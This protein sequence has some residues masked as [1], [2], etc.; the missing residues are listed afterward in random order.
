MK[1]ETK[2]IIL[3]IIL[4][5]VSI[6]FT[7]LV[8]KFD[9]RTVGPNESSVGFSTINS[10]VSQYI[11]SNMTWYKITSILGILPVLIVII[12]GILGIV[13]LV[14]RKSIVK[15]DFEII[16]LGI[17]Y[18]II[19]ILYIFFEK[20]IV[21]YRPILING[22]LEASYP[23]SHTMMAIFICFS[24]NIVNKS[25]IKDDKLR[26]V[27]NILSVIIAF[28]IV[29]GRIISGVHWCSDIVGGVII[30][31]TLL[32]IFNKLLKLKKSKN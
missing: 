22:V 8:L 14:K 12:Y 1:K 27:L 17:F 26:N 18:V 15:V 4:I 28:L 10:K 19:G 6:L 30:S 31:S 2:K 24:A 16:L 13:E 29:I 21:N 7:I 3:C 32:V 25:L 9:V 5:I 23:S 11:G 20:F